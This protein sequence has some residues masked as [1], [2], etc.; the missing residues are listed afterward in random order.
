MRSIRRKILKARCRRNRDGNKSSSPLGSSHQPHTQPG[1]I[2]PTRVALLSP[3]M[4]SVA[5]QDST[6]TTTPLTTMNKILLGTPLAFGHHPLNP[7]HIF[8][9]FFSL[10]GIDTPGFFPFPSILQWSGVQ[11]WWH[12]RLLC[13]D[14][15]VHRVHSLDRITV[16]FAPGVSKDGFLT[17]EMLGTRW[18]NRLSL[19]TFSP[20]NVCLHSLISNPF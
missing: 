13:L 7:S 8:D 16:P 19:S 4:N 5:L 10:A 17:F 14:I 2:T 18:R 12:G 6:A 11:N 15:E 3:D 20:Q 9:L 1:T